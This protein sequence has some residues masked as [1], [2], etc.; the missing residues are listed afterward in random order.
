MKTVRLH[1]DDP[2]LLAF[3]AEVIAHSAHRERASIVPSTRAPIGGSSP[4]IT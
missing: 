4:S 3:D 2:L 1:Y